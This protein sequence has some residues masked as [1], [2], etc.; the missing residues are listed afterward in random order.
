[1]KPEWEVEGEEKQQAVKTLPFGAGPRFSR[2]VTGSNLGP[3]GDDH[4]DLQCDH[5]TFTSATFSVT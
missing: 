1:M 3:D 4:L 2:E 5:P